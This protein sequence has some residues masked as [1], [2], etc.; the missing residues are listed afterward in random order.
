VATIC[1]LKVILKDRSFFAVAVAIKDH[2]DQGSTYMEP[3]A[4]A[5]AQPEQ[6][7]KLSG[8]SSCSPSLL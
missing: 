8:I 3:S 6:N 1:K 7:S 5:D 2:S 4:E